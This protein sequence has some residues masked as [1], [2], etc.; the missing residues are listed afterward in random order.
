MTNIWK[1]NQSSQL[2]STSS[3]NSLKTRC[4]ETYGEELRR[5]DQV[6]PPH[7]GGIQTA[8][9]GDGEHQVLMFEVPPRKMT[10]HSRWFVE[11]HIRNDPDLQCVRFSP[12]LGIAQQTYLP[13]GIEGIEEMGKAT[14]SRSPSPVTCG[15]GVDDCKKTFWLVAG[16]LRAH[17][18]H[19]C[20]SFSTES[21]KHM[22][23]S[24]NCDS[25]PME[26][27]S[28][29][30]PNCSKKAVLIDTKKIRDS[31]LPILIDPSLV[32]VLAGQ[33]KLLRRLDGENQLYRPAR[34][35]SKS[36]RTTGRPLL[37]RIKETRRY[38]KKN[39][40]ILN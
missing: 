32:S 33:G 23:N 15:R 24:Q 1:F 35:P 7:S 27:W 37:R 2:H 36:K 21:E 6:P 17:N 11:R 25:P 8:S 19:V 3:I 18:G 20:R 38:L 26:E 14:Q 5:T 30:L 9:S 34:L 10:H 39:S 28:F 22:T 16:R 29:M 31:D 13:G 4:T 40:C 12:F